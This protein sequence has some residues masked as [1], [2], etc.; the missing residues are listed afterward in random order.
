MYYSVAKSYFPFTLESISRCGLPWL[1][2]GCPV[3]FPSS[4]R[5]VLFFL[6]C[7]TSDVSTQFI[8]QLIT[9]ERFL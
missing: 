3:T 2:A 6:V 7:V 4:F 8:G 9:G 1:L 5:V